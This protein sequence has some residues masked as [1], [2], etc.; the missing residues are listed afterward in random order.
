[1]EL[2]HQSALRRIEAL[3][4]EF[5]D[6]SP[7]IRRIIAIHK[8]PLEKRLAKYLYGNGWADECERRVRY[9]YWL[10]GEDRHSLPCS[11]EPASHTPPNGRA[12][13]SKSTDP[14]S[15]VQ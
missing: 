13:P 8:S 15:P 7:Q 5:A 1:M 6:A 14:R 3:E 2:P 12:S 11:S 10:R 9:N 4:R